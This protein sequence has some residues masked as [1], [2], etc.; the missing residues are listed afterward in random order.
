METGVV[1]IRRSNDAEPCGVG[2]RARGG[3]GNVGVN[4]AGA[5]E[6]KG[7]HFIHSLLAFPHQA[8]VSMPYF[9]VLCTCEGFHLPYERNIFP[10]LHADSHQR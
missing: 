10:T 7:R 4:Q 8:G 5:G 1:R 3:Q 9:L 2:W 6:G